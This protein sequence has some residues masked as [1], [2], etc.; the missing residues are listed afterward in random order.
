MTPF[1]IVY[2]Q[3]CWFYDVCAWEVGWCGAGRGS[4]EEQRSGP[5]Q[6]LLQLPRQPWHLCPTTTAPGMYD[7]G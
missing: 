6:D 2:S 3:V 1:V 4:R 7:T 5:G